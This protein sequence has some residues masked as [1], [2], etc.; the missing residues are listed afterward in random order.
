[1][2]SETGRI[3]GSLESDMPLA[4]KKLLMRANMRRVNSSGNYTRYVVCTAAGVLG[5]YSNNSS[6]HI[7]KTVLAF[8]YEGQ[9]ESMANTIR[10]STGVDVWVEARGNA[11]ILDEERRKERARKKYGKSKTN[12]IRP[13]RVPRIQG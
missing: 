12:G 4:T 3:L 7:K 1:M 9:A 2:N 5:F 11:D 10:N 6:R 13:L 8:H